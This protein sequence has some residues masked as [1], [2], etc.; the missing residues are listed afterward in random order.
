MKNNRSFQYIALL[1]IAGCF[2][3]TSCSEGDGGYY[4]GGESGSGTGGSM[5]RF[6]IKGDY[7]YTVD[8]STLKTFDLTTPDKPKYLSNK[9]QSMSWGIE[10]VFTMDTLL[11]IGS[12]T[13]MYI[14]NITRPEFPQQL[15]E[16]S[17]IRSCDPVVAQGNYAYVTLNSENSWCG[18]TS[19]VLQIYDISNPRKPIM[20]QEVSGFTS[21]KGLGVDNNKLFICDSDKGLK[22]YD[23]SNPL[24]PVWMDDLS[25]LSQAN[26][27]N[28]YDVIPL[29]GL[30]LVVGR[31]GLYQFDYTSEKLAF[32]SKIEINRE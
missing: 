16:V 23:I 32:L 27:I 9:D 12:Q 21:P 29:N 20:L 13:G 14:Y 15:A 24:N 17:H 4:G 31:D 8:H 25:H 1:L 7:M 2:M 6:T 3:F 22:V 10:T 5:A 11:F 26:G 18:R 19:N 28:T 30:L